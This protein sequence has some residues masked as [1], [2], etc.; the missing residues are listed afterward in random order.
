VRAKVLAQTG[1]IEDA[2]RLAM[3]AV[4]VL[5]HTD[6]LLYQADALV[7]RSEMLAR[8]GDPSGAWTALV[9]A[10][11]LYELKGNV[12]AAES[13]RASL[14]EAFYVN[15]AQAGLRQCSHQ[16]GCQSGRMGRS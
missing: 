13:T 4:E 2:R 1:K 7:D 14:A 3:E 6:G 11:R 5:E 9:E 10:L 12:V 15:A 16:A 8:T